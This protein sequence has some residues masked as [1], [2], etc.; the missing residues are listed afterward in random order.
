MG[1]EGPVEGG[2]GDDEDGEGAA[3]LEPLAALAPVGEGDGGVHSGAVAAAGDG[4]GV[5]EGADEGVVGG[6]GWWGS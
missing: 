2:V 5:V 3:E 1:G 4:A 6:G